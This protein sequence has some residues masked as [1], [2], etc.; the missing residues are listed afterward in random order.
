MKPTISAT[1][2]VIAGQHKQCVNPLPGLMRMIDV[3]ESDEI[4]LPTI[5]PLEI[6]HLLLRQLQ[7]ECSDRD[8]GDDDNRRIVAFIERA[9]EFHEITRLEF[10]GVDG[11][12][13]C[14]NASYY[15]WLFLADHLMHDGSDSAVP[16]IFKLAEQWLRIGFITE[17]TYESIIGNTYQ[18]HKDRT[19][20]DQLAKSRQAKR[21][22]LDG[23]NTG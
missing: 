4:D 17:R 14:P 2:W 23:G 3:H 11:R 10:E 7:R 1:R 5:E 22:H 20:R 21:Q 13:I 15:W 19:V 8:L 6:L 16:M 18:A 12:H 9:Q